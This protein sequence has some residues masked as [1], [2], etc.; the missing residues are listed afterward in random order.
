MQQA[1]V[2]TAEQQYAGMTDRPASRRAVVQTLT[3]LTA[4]AALPAIFPAAAHAGVLPNA[5]GLV[6]ALLNWQEGRCFQRKQH[7]QTHASD[8]PVHT[9][10]IWQST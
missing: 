4:A 1:C 9:Q 8:M 3:A 6:V 10:T 7:V 5:F 2:T